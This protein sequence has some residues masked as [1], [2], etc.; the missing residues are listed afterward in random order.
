VLIRKAYRF[1]LYPTDAQQ[2]LLARQFGCVRWVYNHF[3]ARRKETYETTGEGLNYKETAGELVALKRTEGL[4]WLREAHSQTLQQGLK[5]LDA[6]YDRFFSKQNRYPKFKKRHA[7]QSCRY[8]QGVRVEREGREGQVYLPKIGWLRCVAHCKVDGKIK[9]VT[10]SKTAAGRYFVSV[11]VEMEHTIPKPASGM[12]PEHRSVGIDLG[13]TH[14]ATLSNGEK[15]DSLCYL[16]KSEQRRKRLQ[17]RVSRR[18]KGSKGRERA[19]LELARQHEKVANKRSDFLHKLSR[20]LVDENQVLAVEDLN[21][22][23]MLRNRH[24]SKSI[25]DASWSEFLRQ[26]RYK[27]EWYGCQVIT[28]DRFYASS[29]RCHYCGSKNHALRLS[30]RV[31]TCEICGMT[32]D[33]D[34]NA[35]L[36]IVSAATAG[37]VESY[38]GGEGQVQ[39][40]VGA[41]PHRTPNQMLSAESR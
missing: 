12:R 15:I 22:K 5:D 30:D 16:R 36:N 26:L 4:E 18:V 27:G 8:P 1:R 31:W 14:F 11:Q 7:K 9:Q 25:S 33:R 6:A 41:A 2:N 39:L 19:R 29:K 32:H 28:I 13:L 23:G 37:T 35:A 21:V 34:L 10:V 20:R 3:L 38:A 17:R 24:L 40:S